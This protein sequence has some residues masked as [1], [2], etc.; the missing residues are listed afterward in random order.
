[1]LFHVIAAVASVAFVAQSALAQQTVQDVVNNINQVTQMAQNAKTALSGITELTG[2]PQVISSAQALEVALNNIVGNLNA[3]DTQEESTTPFTDCTDAEPIV[4]ALSNVVGALREFLSTIIGKQ[5]V[6]AQYTALS[7]IA[8]AL[9]SF[10]DAID[11]SAQPT[12]NLLPPCDDSNV[13]NGEGELD[14]PLAEAIRLYKQ[15][16]IKSLDYPSIPPFCFSL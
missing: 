10:K 16:C 11:S 13:I 3:E 7:P 8:T 14:Y 12:I 9:Q 5:I 6:F 1:M 15:T 2:G 4:D